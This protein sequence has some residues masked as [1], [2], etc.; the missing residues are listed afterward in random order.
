M[1]IKLTNIRNNPIGDVLCD[2]CCLPIALDEDCSYLFGQDDYP[3]LEPLLVHN[4][5]FRR[6]PRERLRGYWA[7]LTHPRTI[8]KSII[9]SPRRSRYPQ[10]DAL[11]NEIKQQKQKHDP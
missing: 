6:A 7:T 3:N 2:I 1:H 10:L 11:L 9:E 5:C 8:L 4:P